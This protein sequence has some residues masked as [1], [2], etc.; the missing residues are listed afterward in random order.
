LKNPD[1]TQ[2]LKKDLFPQLMPG[3]GE[4]TDTQFKKALE[5]NFGALEAHIKTLA[6]WDLPLREEHRLPAAKR[7]WHLPPREFI[8]H[9]QKCGWLSKDELYQLF[10]KM[11]LRKDRH[12]QWLNE[13]VRPQNDNL[14]N[15]L[16]SLN[17]ACR[18]YGITTPLRLAGFYANAMQETQ[19]FRAI[20]EGGASSAW[21]APWFG[22]GF[23]QLTH[24]DNCIK[25]WR[26]IGR[27]VSQQLADD[28]A[29]AQ[30]N[31]RTQRSSQQLHNREQDVRQAGLH[32]W[33]DELANSADQYHPANSAGAYW[34]WSEAA[35][36]ADEQPQNTRATADTY[37]YYTSPGMGGVAGTV[38]IG[39]P[40][41]NYSAINGIQARFQAYSSAEMVLMDTMTFPRAQG[42]PQ[43]SPEGYTPRRPRP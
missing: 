5:K 36:Y 42:T 28:L 25:Y 16:L 20:A 10:P 35:R 13:P 1:E 9:M 11:A 3:A 24:P 23:L 29:R 31:A 27:T 17:K 32:V 30:S 39:H 34:V 43:L 21:Y 2:I 38:N 19:W 26:F 41:N 12:N 40:T 14:S 6:F 15:Q 18:R 37:V 4:V 8:K 22:R 7:C 33:R